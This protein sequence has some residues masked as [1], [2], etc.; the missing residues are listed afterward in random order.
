MRELRIRVEVI[1][2]L[3]G[4][5]LARAQRT[6]ALH[7]EVEKLRDLAGDGL[8]TIEFKEVTPRLRDVAKAVPRI[9]TPLERAA[10]AAAEDDDATRA[11]DHPILGDDVG[12]ARTGIVAADGSVTLLGVHGGEDLLEIP[13]FL[14]R[15]QARASGG[16]S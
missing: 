6:V 1:V 3:A 9:A 5:A 12:V 14:D 2:P 15:R 8:V 11:S 10:A 4:D 7:Q 13:P 16:A